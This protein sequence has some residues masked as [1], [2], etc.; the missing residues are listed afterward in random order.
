MS[1]GPQY[2][3]PAD[4]PLSSHNSAF[5]LAH[6][7][8]L[9]QSIQLYMKA[10]VLLGRVVSFMQRAKSPIGMSLNPTPGVGQPDLRMTYVA[11]PRLKSLRWY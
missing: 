9:V 5:L 10:V 11:L 8:H 1:R 4:S 6:P 3:N 2:D 7:P